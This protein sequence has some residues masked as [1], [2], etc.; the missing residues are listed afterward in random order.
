MLSVNNLLTLII[1]N[2]KYFAFSTSLKDFI[3]FFC[4]CN[5]EGR[6]DSPTKESRV[7]LASWAVADRTGLGALEFR[8]MAFSSQP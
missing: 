4:F 5:Q 1:T 8:S 2:I 6:S 7:T 3:F